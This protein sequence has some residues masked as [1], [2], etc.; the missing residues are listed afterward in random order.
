MMRQSQ[1]QKKNCLITL[2]HGVFVE[3]FNGTRWLSKLRPAGASQ[4]AD[5]P[6]GPIA[7]I[8]TSGKLQK[9]NL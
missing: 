8:V 6:E 2:Q 9:K 5:G 3:S 7:P 4:K 1:H